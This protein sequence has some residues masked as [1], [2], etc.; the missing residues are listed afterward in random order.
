[1]SRS[2]RALSKAAFVLAACVATT[3][4]AVDRFPM[5]ATVHAQ[6]VIYKPGDGVTLPEVVKDV[7]PQYTAAAMQAKIQGS[8]LLDCVVGETGDI[9]DITVTKSLDTEYG[10]DQAAIDAA[11]QW[12]FK[13]GRRDGEPVAVRI[14][15]E[16]TFT[17]KK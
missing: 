3:T 14:A 10:L 12:K 7:K 4:I 9:V 6:S 8:V 5:F 13:P 15:I 1:M 16:L 2:R 11:G 17:L